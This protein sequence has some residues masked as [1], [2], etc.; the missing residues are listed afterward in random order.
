MNRHRFLSTLWW[1]DFSKIGHR[2]TLIN[3]DDGYD[4][5]GNDDVSNDDDDDYNCLTNAENR[6]IFTP[7]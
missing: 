4:D 5:D 6:Y 2:E 3:D 7:G 1:E